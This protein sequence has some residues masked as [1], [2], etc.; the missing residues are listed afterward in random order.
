MK[1]L[2]IMASP[3]KGGNSDLLLD[4]FLRGVEE[5]GGEF[6]KLSVGDL[7]I[8]PCREILACEKDGECVIK[9]E[10]D[11]VYQKLLEAEKIVIAS[12][13]FFYGFPAHFKALIDRCQVLWVRKHLLGIE[14]ANSPKRAFALLLGATKGE[15]LFDGVLLTLRYFLEP[16]NAGLSGTLL[17]R[18][19]EKKGDI[20]N[21]P[22]A[23]K[24]AYD[25]GVRFGRG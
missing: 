20:Q 3:R 6:E 4:E 8:S 19:V 12:P 1:I 5:G 11:S 9:D 22:T 18:K 25:A 14:P 23:M 13:I 15:R 10:M 24:E 2:A 7:K 16:L 21:H 17:Y